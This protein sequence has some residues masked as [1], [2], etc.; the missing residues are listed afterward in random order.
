MRRDFNAVALWF[1][2][3][4]LVRLPIPWYNPAD[5]DHWRKLKE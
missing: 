4:G 1:N 2:V 5:M 3:T